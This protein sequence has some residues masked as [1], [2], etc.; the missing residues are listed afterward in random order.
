M[1][2]ALESRKANQIL[3]NLGLFSF[4]FYS[5]AYVEDAFSVSLALHGN[6]TFDEAHRMLIYIS[7]PAASFLYV[8]I[9]SH[10]FHKYD[11][12]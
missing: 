10:L 2:K 5:V 3:F 8:L 12:L 7:A 4:N 9:S 1:N 6:F 11:N